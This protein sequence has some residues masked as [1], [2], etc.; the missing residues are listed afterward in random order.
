[1]KYLKLSL[2]LIFFFSA[3]VNA[4]QPPWLNEKVSEENRM[5]MHASYFVYENEQQAKT[6]N[7][8][9]SANYLNLNGDWKFKW[10]EK[11]ADLPENFQAVKFNDSKWDNFKIPATWEV[12]GYGYPI[13][14]NIG[15]EFQNIMKPNPPIV[16][17]SFD[18]TGVYRKE[19]TIDNKWNGKQI[20][21]HIGSAKSNLSVW[22]N[23]KYT[24][25]GEDSKL[26]SEFD[27]TPFVKTGKNL[28]AL[29][30]M[31]W[32]DG[33]Y[34][35]GQDFWRLG[36][37]MRDCYL[38]ARNP[39]HITDFELHPTLDNNYID[40]ILH[41]TISL[42]KSA[43]ASASLEIYDGINLINQTN[44]SF[45]N[46]SKRIINIPIAKPKLWSAEVPNLYNVIIKLKDR[47]GATLEVIPQ[48]I[49]FREVR[50]KNGMLLVNGKPI[51]IKG[52][53]RHE[54]DPVTGQTISKEAMLKDVQLM[55]QFNINAVR[56]CH[57]PND[58]Y[59]Y[60]LCDEYGLYVVDE[61]DIES[62]GIG[63]EIAK[64]L[65]NRPSWRDAHVIR[66][67]RMIER[68]INHPSI[69]I[70]SLGNE[71]GDG[72][73][74]Y[75]SYLWIKSRDTSRP[76]QYEG[77]VVNN[78]TFPVQFNTDIVNP[79]YPTPANMVKYASNNLTPE[80]PFIMCEYAHAM[81]NSLGN[82]TDYWNI[83]RGSNNTFQGGFIWDFVDQGLL[84]ITAKGDTIYTYGGDY[85]PKDV[86]SDNNFND[87]GLFYP[88]RRPNPHAWEMKKVYQNI[89][90]K[91]TNNNMLSVYNENFFKDLSDVRME[92][93]LIVNGERK[94]TG[95]MDDVNVLAHATKE[96]K[97]P[98]QMPT[99]GEAFLNVVYK[100]KENKFL[101]E[102]DHI[103]AYE[104]LPLGGSFKNS[105]TIASAG[106]LSVNEDAS[107]YTITSPIATIRFN[108]QS[109]IPDNYVVNGLN[110]VE[111]TGGVKPAFWRAPTDND[112]GAGLQLKLKQ[113]KLAQ[114][115]LQ[116]VSFNTQNKNNLVEVNAS[117]N[118]PE[119]FAKLNVKY[120]INSN[121]EML[122]NQ[123]IIA[124][125]TANVAMM[126][127]F[128]MN[129]I[130]PQGFE[131]IE[132]YG[133]GP[134]ENYLDRFS[135]TPVGIYKQTVKEQF[136]PYMRPQETGNK[137]GIRWFKITNAQ[138]KGI[139][140]QSE[141]LLS[142][143]A[144]HFYDDDLDDGDKKHQRHSGEL[145]PRKQTQL[146]IDYKQMGLGGIN[147]WGS[148]PLEQYR[149]PYKNYSYSFK[150][151]PL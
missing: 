37:I 100:Q 70:W 47:S 145:E 54:T 71:A 14:V 72:Y 90:T 125:D 63:F 82:F 65:A 53:N 110:L 117:Y 6:D 30:V 76:I 130:L 105:I 79:M 26:P 34:L 132:F 111:Q 17:L 36:G 83:I 92:W 49:G 113:W 56:T 44:I 46:V 45:V 108:K 96:F 16:P 68:D 29:K 41:T 28:I 55:K 31:R 104:Q 60:E 22:I 88:D 121:G 57:Y 67:Q 131:T 89:I 7:W 48:R 39:I 2:G 114:Q 59:W 141:S 80:K 69:I 12:N 87:N 50:I 119:V 33:T 102:K 107:N 109:G 149:L 24:G 86:P 38:V 58:E 9:Q 74:F 5:P 8:K 112:M 139:L 142:M 135:N 101:V 35:E 40:A 133:R 129:W 138:G 4:Q 122:V 15:Y 61:A 97:L 98:V 3:I 140:I 99:D 10:V 123:N 93:E 77:A 147:S 116:L 25:Y 32:S 23:G 1:M 62:H 42:N 127:R 64:T 18:P 78:N 11:P 73:N 75:E 13:Y 143:S 51:L 146:H 94:Q 81:G 136:Y 148:L 120:T 137:T 95:T 134:N 43:A 52:A 103:V 150:V 84:K 118:L 128:G 66:T 85:G 20:I 126:P 27:I 19:I 151:S 21:L 106:N 144:L 115:N 91:L 124:N